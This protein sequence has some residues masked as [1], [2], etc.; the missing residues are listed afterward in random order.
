MKKLIISVLV[1]FSVGMPPAA[2]LWYKENLAPSTSYVAPTAPEI[3]EPLPATEENILKRV[4]EERAKVSVKP[5]IAHKDITKSA[6]LKADDM[7]DRDYREHRLPENPNA[8]LTREMY[9]YIEPHCLMS[10]ENFTYNEDK[11]EIM[12]A[13]NAVTGWLNSPPH[14]EAM[15]DPK[16][17]YTGI[18]VSHDNIVVQHFCVA[19]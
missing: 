1:L 4:N 13:E 15:L 9:S 8:T 17:T 6:Q 2:Y 7:W 5:L 18:G 11:H 10:S 12:H 3:Y 19:K 14:K 16:Y